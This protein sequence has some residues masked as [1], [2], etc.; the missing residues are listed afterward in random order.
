[1]L[2]P[3]RDLNEIPLATVCIALTPR[4]S[5]QGLVQGSVKKDGARA[6]KKREKE[7]DQR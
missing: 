3:V 1:M 4:P 7:N 5:Q 6:G 2:L